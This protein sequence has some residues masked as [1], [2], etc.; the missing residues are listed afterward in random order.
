MNFRIHILYTISDNAKRFLEDSFNL[1]IRLFAHRDTNEFRA[2][3][4]PI[5][6]L[7]PLF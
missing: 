4:N 1:F 6:E 3:T 7:T 5:Q 2:N